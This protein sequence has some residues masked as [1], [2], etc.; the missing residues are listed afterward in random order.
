[1]STRDDELDE[2]YERLARNICLFRRA[3]GLSHAG[4]AACS[5]VSV[6]QIRRLER[7]WPPG[8]LCGY[9]RKAR[10]RV[11][12][13]THG[14]GLRHS[15]SQASQEEGREWVASIRR[16]R[17]DGTLNPVWWVKYYVGGRPKRVSTR[18][19]KFKVAEKFLREREGRVAR[20]EPILPRADR[21]RW[22]EAEADLRQHYE[23]TGARDLAEY[24]RRVAHLRKRFAGRLIAEIGQADADAYV[25][26]RQGQGV[27]GA[28]IRRELSTLTKML[29]IAYRNGKLTRLPLLDKP[30]EGPARQG[31]FEREQYEAVRRKLP[32]DLQVAVTIAYTFG[33]RMQSEVLALERRQLDLEA[34]T[35]RLDA[36]QTKNGEGRVVSLTS[37]LKGL[38]GAQITRVDALQRR[39]G[40]IVPALFPHGGKGVRAGTPRVDF[41]KA[42]ATA[43]QAAGV[44]G[45]HRHD[46][47]RSA[48]RNMEQA[49]VPRSVAMKISGHLTEN[50]YRRYAIVSP[51]DLEAATRLIERRGTFRGTHNS[52]ALES[53]VQASEIPQIG[54]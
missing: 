54:G 15:T 45:K 6:S 14:A 16:K 10:T 20:G 44:P 43:C 13:Q 50:V 37:E 25:I 1:M 27:V 46:F 5:G 28:T 40:R 8:S 22:E 17:R 32:V 52:G 31:F 51:E 21:V 53:S 4:L 42:W 36:G 34:G 49:G 29:R 19:A 39:L 3:Q 47:R 24:D 9:G 18:T 48:V 11:G 23:A 33:W 7:C 38:L 41:R 12:C 2:L 35:L 30:K 26:H